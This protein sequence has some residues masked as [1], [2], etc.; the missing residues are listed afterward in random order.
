MTNTISRAK[1]A[2]VPAERTNPQAGSLTDLLHEGFYLVLLLRNGKHASSAESF[3]SGVADYLEDFEKR[4]KADGHAT[5][6]VIDAKYAF[7]ALVDET[8]LAYN[9]G[10]R[11]EWERC[12]LQLRL[13]G[14]QLAGEHFFD[15]MERARN[16]GTERIG[17]I[18]VFHM[19]LLL[20]F[21]GRY[22]IEQSEQLDYL[23]AQ[24]GAQIMHLKG[25]A[26]GFAPHWKAADGVIN[27]IERQTPMWV[28]SSVL[29]L[30]GLLAFIGLRWHLD[31]TL[32]EALGKYDGIVTHAE[33]QPSITISLP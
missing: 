22:R 31:R 20:G 16:A 18:E 17:A 12:P 32:T 2:S 6:D 33:K 19:C 4:A 7:S 1:S 10:I 25:H 21:K 30:A 26:N 13:F 28:I 27:R 3:S 5:E 15:R 14:D 11:D 8:V 23:C 29:L 9:A 24:V